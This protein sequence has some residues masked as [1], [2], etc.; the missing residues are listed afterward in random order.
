MSLDGLVRRF[1]YGLQNRFQHS[2][3]FASTKLLKPRGRR[4]VQRK[5]DDSLVI[6]PGKEEF[7]CVYSY[8]MYK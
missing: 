8:E 1:P 2:R 7:P 3:A 6:K 4:A 5:W